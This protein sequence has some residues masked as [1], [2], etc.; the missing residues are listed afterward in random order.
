MEQFGIHLWLA[1]DM[2]IQRSPLCGRNFE[3]YSEDPV[4]SGNIAAAI[5][6]GVQSHKG[7]GT[8]IK[9]FA[10]NNQESNRMASNS[11][12]SERAIRE[13]YLRNFEICVEKSAPETI[14]SSYN[15]VNGEHANNSKDIQTY[16]LRDEWGYKGTVMTDWYA[17]GG[18]MSQAG[19]RTDKHA[20]GLA[21]GCIHAGNDIT[22]PGM[23]SDFDDM[24]HALDNKDAKYPITRA[25]LQ[26]TAKRVLR[27]V[28]K[29]A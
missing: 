4:V 16:V 9:H 23:Q 2:N 7:C 1:P 6:L 25:E 15:L 27:T 26:V 19:G 29:L 17:V 10:L 3:Y 22:M 13:I 11:I 18:M 5:T 12:A 20:A 28:L 21:S 14:M 8:T 24:L